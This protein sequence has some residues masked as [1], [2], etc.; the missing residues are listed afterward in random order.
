MK[1][2]KIEDKLQIVQNYLLPKLFEEYNFDKNEIIFS[3]KVVKHIIH[4]FTKEEGVRQIK[5]T[6]DTIISKL[7]LYKITN[8]KERN[9][10]NELFKQQYTFPLKL[11]IE[12]VNKLVVKENNIPLSVQMMYL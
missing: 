2:F 3:D 7:N 12:N 8:C 1:G 10:Q 4:N 11:T 9:I 6:L 5:Q